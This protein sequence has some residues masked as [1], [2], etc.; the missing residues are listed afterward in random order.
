MIG[1]PSCSWKGTT[2][3]VFLQLSFLL[4]EEKNCQCMEVNE[5]IEVI[6]KLA[7]KGRASKITHLLPPPIYNK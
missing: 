7:I 5:V 4:K 1:Q 6:E 3:V 2:G